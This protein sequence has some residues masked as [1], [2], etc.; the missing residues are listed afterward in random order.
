MSAQMASIIRKKPQTVYEAIMIFLN[1]KSEKTKIEYQRDIE[2]FFLYMYGKPMNQIT[3]KDLECFELDDEGKPQPLSNMHVIQ[4][5][6]H[7]QQKNSNST[8]MRKIYA[9]K[10][11]FRFLQ[12]NRYKVEAEAFKVKTLKKKTQS[13]DILTPEQVQTMAE[14]AKNERHGDEMS[15]WI[16]LAAVTSIR[17]NATLTLTWNDVRYDEESDLY[18]VTAHEKRDEIAQRPIEKWLYDDLQ[19]IRKKYGSEKLFPHLKVDK[20]EKTIKRLATKMGIP[21]YK[22]IVPHSLRKTAID[23]EMKTSG[24]VLKAKQQSGH[25]SVQVL[26][27]HYT[28]KK[29]DYSD[30]AG[31]RMMKKVDESVFE[32]LSKEELLK[33]LK[34]TN[35]GVYGQLAVKAE[36]RRG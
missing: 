14:L 5:K 20:V 21:E 27:D 36:Q 13:Y 25:K 6:E 29:T 33:L 17:L 34:E 30:L 9:V 24:S 18:I 8:V 16:N 15:A 3:K 1:E 12:G 35:K 22:R 2:E 28:D 11:L 19:A 31:I 4:Y 23:Y 10:A 26:I 7:L 32:N